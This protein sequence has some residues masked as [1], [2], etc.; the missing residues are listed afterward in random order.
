[1]RADGLWVFGTVDVSVDV[2]IW[3]FYGPRKLALLLLAIPLLEM[4]FTDLFY[5]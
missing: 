2:Y 1:M 3:R 5:I 4:K